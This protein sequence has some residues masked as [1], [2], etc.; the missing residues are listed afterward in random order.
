[1]HAAS[2]HAVAQ[3][4]S[5]FYLWLNDDTLLDE[6]ALCV[7]LAMQDELRS[8]QSS[9][10]GSIRCHRSTTS[11]INWTRRE[12]VAARARRLGEPSPRGVLDGNIQ[13]ALIRAT[14]CCGS[15]AL[16]RSIRRRPTASMRSRRRRHRR[17]AT[18]MA[19]TG[20]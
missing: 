20:R 9:P 1:M 10:S 11:R 16:R 5:D 8:E 3:H 2:A 6:T 4:T 13:I 14:L 19:A 15:A 12:V 18:A 17:C 7:L